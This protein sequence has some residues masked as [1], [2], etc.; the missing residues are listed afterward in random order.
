V[1]LTRSTRDISGGV[2]GFGGWSGDCSGTGACTLLLDI[3]KA[4]T[5]TF[6]ATKPIKT[7]MTTT[8]ISLA[9]PMLVGQTVTLTATVNQG[10]AT[11]I[12]T[13]KYGDKVLDTVPI[14][15][16]TAIYATSVLA[17]ATHRF[18]AVHSG[19]ANYLES[20]SMMLGQCVQRR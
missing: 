18:T 8:L 1:V 14:T 6:T 5:A 15:G 7:A 19:D 10:A 13:F 12:V 3:A 9:N 2:T 4:V 11:G 16:G 20:T 17:Q